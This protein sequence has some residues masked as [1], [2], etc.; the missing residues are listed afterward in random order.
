MEKLS[1]YVEKLLVRYDY[2]IVPDLGG[3]VVQNQSARILQNRIVPPLSTLGFNPLLKDSDGL[4]AIAIAQE[5][6]ISY[7]AA[8]E[9]IEKEVE[10]IHFQLQSAKIISLGKLGFLKRNELGKLVFVPAERVDF[11]PANF[12]MTDIQFFHEKSISSSQNK[13]ITITLPSASSMRNVA[14]TV[15]VCALL[16]VSPRIADTRRSFYTASFPLEMKRSLQT[17]KIIEKSTSVNFSSQ[18]I[19]TISELSTSEQEGKNITGHKYPYHVIVASFYTEKTAEKFCESLHS[20]GFEKA[21]VISPQKNYKVV[22]QSFI[23]YNDAVEFLHH[24]RHSE[25]QFASAWVFIDK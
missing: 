19:N 22:L 21:H 9:W 24:L 6:G 17:E 20:I 8:S 10:L 11:L 25:P 23:E 3:F 15:L 18:V 16:L 14:A 1:Y 13:K 4:L 2:V 5:E 7:Q 12:G